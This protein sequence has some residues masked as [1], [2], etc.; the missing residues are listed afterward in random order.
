MN[1]TTKTFLGLA[2]AIVFPAFAVYA[3]ITF[4]PAQANTLQE[5][6]YVEQPSAPTYD[7]C[8]QIAAGTS[9]IAATLSQACVQ[10]DNATYATQQSA[11]R[12]YQ[13]SESAYHKAIA[14]QAD[15]SAT[16]LLYRVM[17]VLAIAFAGIIGTFFVVAIPPLV[18]GLV[19]GATLMLFGSI[20]TLLGASTKVQGQAA[21]VLAAIFLLTTIMMIAYERNLQE[22]EA[23]ITIPPSL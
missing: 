3:A 5:P 15:A 13:N 7:Y 23:A 20:S 8:N 14:D 16:L 19:S 17:L 18:Y 6:T 21:I 4:L 12:T 1:S 11:Y 9:K 22:P 2:I 10:Q